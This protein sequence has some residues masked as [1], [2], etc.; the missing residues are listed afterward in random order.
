MTDN[1]RNKSVSFE[2]ETKTNNTRSDSFLLE[3]ANKAKA[4]KLAIEI[5][6]KFTAR[7]QSFIEFYDLDD[8][9]IH[10]TCGLAISQLHLNHSE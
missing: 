4:E 5:S 1:K 9:G 3:K 6:E 8:K 7:R 10:E 2:G